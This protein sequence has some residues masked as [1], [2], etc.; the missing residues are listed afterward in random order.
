[1]QYGKS[2]QRRLRN[3]HSAYLK[4]LRESIKRPTGQAFISL[5]RPASQAAHDASRRQ[6]AG[7]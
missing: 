5:N 2:D 1:L 7:R 3:H 4:L 6:E